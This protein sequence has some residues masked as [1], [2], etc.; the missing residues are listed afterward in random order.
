MSH[1]IVAHAHIHTHSLHTDTHTH[2]H[3]NTKLLLFTTITKTLQSQAKKLRAPLVCHF[4]YALSPTHI[5][6]ISHRRARSLSLSASL[7]E[8]GVSHAVEAQNTRRR[9]QLRVR[10][11]NVR[12]ESKSRACYQLLKNLTVCAQK[13]ATENVVR[14]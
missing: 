4:S 3:S 13:Y 6:S 1:V 14:I 11:S 2:T 8:A 9:K 12:I 7:L 10:A 5:R